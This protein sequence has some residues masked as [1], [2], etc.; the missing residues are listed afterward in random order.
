MSLLS[1]LPNNRLRQRPPAVAT[2][3]G[4][5]ASVQLWCSITAMV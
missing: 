4:Q 5:Y 1:M 2:T 3:P